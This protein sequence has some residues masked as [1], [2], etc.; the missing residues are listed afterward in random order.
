MEHMEPAT[1]LQSWLPVTSY[2]ILDMLGNLS[3]PQFPHMS[4]GDK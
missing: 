1:D 2:V 4:N 3:E